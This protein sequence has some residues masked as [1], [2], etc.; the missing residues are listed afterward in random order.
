M[1]E[2]FIYANKYR[3]AIFEELSAGEYNINRIA[4][5]HRIFPPI[6]KRVMNEFEQANIVE[7]TKGRYNFTKKGE[8]LKQTIG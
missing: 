5:K 2:G 8:R 1:D 3:R 6:V 7:F 4:K